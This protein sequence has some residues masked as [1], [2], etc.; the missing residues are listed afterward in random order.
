MWRAIASAADRALPARI[1][2]GQVVGNELARGADDDDVPDH[3]RRAR[4]PPAR[5][6]RAGVGRNVARPHDSAVTGVERVEDP[7]RTECVDATLAEGRRR[8]RTRSEEHTSELQSPYD[9]V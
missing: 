1:A 2:A 6:L 5:D 3:Q 7:G 4:E 9:L 8:A